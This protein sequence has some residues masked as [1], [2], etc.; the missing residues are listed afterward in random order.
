MDC[1]IAIIEFGDNEKKES[2]LI[3]GMPEEAFNQ[4]AHIYYYSDD[5]TLEEAY[6]EIL[7][8]KEHYEIIWVLSP[9]PEHLQDL[10]CQI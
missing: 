4:P 7:D 1:K 8:L 3:Q 5:I 10:L 9:L 2:V 6:Q